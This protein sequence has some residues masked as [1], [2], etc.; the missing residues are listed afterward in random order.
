[1][2]NNQ[3]NNRIGH[4]PTHYE[5]QVTL[6]FWRIVAGVFNREGPLIDVQSTTTTVGYTPIKARSAS[7]LPSVNNY[8]ELYCVVIVPAVAL[9]SYLSQSSPSQYEP[10]FAQEKKTDL[11]H[12]VACIANRFSPFPLL[13]DCFMAII[14]TLA[15]INCSKDWMETNE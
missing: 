7:N 15:L 8:R 13:Y 1:M 12:P 5:Y 11:I 10:T 6:Y 2:D 14:T 3:T 4:Y 9:V